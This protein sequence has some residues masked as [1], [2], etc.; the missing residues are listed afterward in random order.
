MGGIEFFIDGSKAMLT[1]YLRVRGEVQVLGLISICIESTLALTY[2]SGNGKL[3]GSCEWVLRV[4]VV[5]IR[6]TVRVRFEKRFAG[7]NGDPTF[8]ELM[9]PAGATEP[10]PWDLYCGAYAED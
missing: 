5:F 9:A 3:E 7:A 10:L 1:G 8:A 4:K 2:N 6:K